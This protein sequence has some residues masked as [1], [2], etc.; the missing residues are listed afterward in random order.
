[1]NKTM[2]L[3]LAVCAMPHIF[4]ASAFADDQYPAS[5][6]KPTVTYVDESAVQTQSSATDDQYPAAN[7]QPKVTFIDETV[8]GEAQTDAGAVVDEKY[9]A[10][11]FQSKVIYSDESAAAAEVPEDPDFPAAYYKPK[12]IFP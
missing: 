11:N 2:I 10:A 1:M 9:P 7:F 6:F 4:C 8:K 5:D 3:A 12:V